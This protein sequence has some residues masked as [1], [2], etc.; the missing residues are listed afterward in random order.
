MRKTALQ[1]FF[2]II[3]FLVP[4]I[5]PVNGYYQKSKLPPGDWDILK[6]GVFDIYYE[7]VD[8]EAAELLADL[9]EKKLPEFSEKLKLRIPNNITVFIAPNES[10][11]KYLTHGLPEW[12][13]GAVYPRQRTV[14]L[15]TPRKLDKKGVFSTTALHESVHLLTELDGDS[16]LPR[17]FAEGL[18]FYLSG[19]TLFKNR[20]P[21]AKAV[22]LKKTFTLDE[23]DEVLQFNPGEA[24]VAYLQSISMVEYL[25]DNYGW[26]YISGLIHAYRDNKDVEE[27]TL[28]HAGKPLL[29]IEIAWHQSLS[30]KYRLWNLVEWFDLDMAI[31]GS[32]SLLVMVVGIVTIYRRKRNL[33]EPDGEEPGIFED[34]YGWDEPTWNEDS[35]DDPWKNQ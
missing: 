32:A 27:F 8:L 33:E 21:L 6:S 2:I 30:K 13:G 14:I 23:I 19:E 5:T 26:E 10:R 18:A 22:V 34:A 17:W 1:I 11:F 24:R 9:Y 16:H 29:D 15:K 25:V 7:P 31:W 20:V 28:K 12:T 35:T 3:V 4:L